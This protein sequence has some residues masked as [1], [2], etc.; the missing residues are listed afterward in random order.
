MFHNYLTTV[1]DFKKEFQFNHGA[2]FTGFWESVVIASPITSN[3][4]FVET[5]VSGISETSG[6]KYI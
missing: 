2:W 4:N 5:Y 6:M 1:N 3:V